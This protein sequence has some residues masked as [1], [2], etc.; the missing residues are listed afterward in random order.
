MYSDTASEKK[1]NPTCASNVSARSQPKVLTIRN[2]TVV[3]Q[4]EKKKEFRFAHHVSSFWIIGGIRHLVPVVCCLER[5]L[6]AIELKYIFIAFICKG[7]D[8]ARGMRLL[9]ASPDSPLS[10]QFHSF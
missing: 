2:R 8:A 10:Q 6:A 4:K 1:I 3:C 7:Q 5:T 9:E